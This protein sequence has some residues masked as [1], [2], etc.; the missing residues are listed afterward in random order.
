MKLVLNLGLGSVNIAVKPSQG[1]DDVNG[2]VVVWS[3]VCVCAE[4]HSDACASASSCA[5][6]ECQTYLVWK[7]QLSRSLPPLNKHT[8][9]Y[10]HSLGV[11]RLSDVV[12]VGT[13]ERRVVSKF[14]GERSGRNE[15]RK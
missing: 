9:L 6:I 8:G 10:V 3:F 7:S 14:G 1:L 5:F 11:C 15:T 12:Y 2:Q 13:E 4:V